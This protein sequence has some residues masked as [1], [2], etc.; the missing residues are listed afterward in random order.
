MAI[1]DKYDQVKQLIQSCVK[2][3]GYLVYDEVSEMAPAEVGGGGV[4]EVDDLLTTFSGAGMEVIE[5]EP[6]I[7]DEK[8]FDRKLDEVG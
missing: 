1:E 8:D 6:R 4:D 2:E 5:G 7:G 3:K